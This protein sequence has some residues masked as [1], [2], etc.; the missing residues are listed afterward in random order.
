M[1]HPN[2]SIK[3]GLGIFLDDTRETADL[4][5]QTCS[6][7]LADAV[8]LALRGD[9]KPG[10]N[11]IYTEFIE[12]PGDLELLLLGKRY[13]WSLLSIAKSCVKNANSFINKRMN[14]VE[15][16]SPQRFRVS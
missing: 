2:I 8:K 3:T 6:C 15:D 12:L 13:S 14:V 16:D 7:D 5:V 9:G 10:F 1:H 4:G 11:N